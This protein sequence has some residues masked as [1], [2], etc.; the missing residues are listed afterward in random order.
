[1]PSRRQLQIIGFVLSIVVLIANIIL[2]V[3][4][5]RLTGRVSA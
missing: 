4:Y 1:M 2:G 5:T 3:V